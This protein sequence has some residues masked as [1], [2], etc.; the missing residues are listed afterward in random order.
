MT[1]AELS[2]LIQPILAR[3]IEAAKTDAA[4]REQL[5]QLGEALLVLA[6]DSGP[7]AAGSAAPVSVLSVPSGPSRPSGPSEFDLQILEPEPLET[8]TPLNGDDLV[9][10]D[11]TD[12]EEAAE[13]RSLTWDR[14]LVQVADRDLLDIAERCTLKAQAARE[15]ADWSRSSRDETAR[16]RHKRQVEG[17]IAQAR[18]VPDCYLFLN[19]RELTSNDPAAFDTVAGCFDATAAIVALL[20]DIVMDADA[21]N[22][23]QAMALAAE[24]QSAL[25]HAVRATTYLNDKDQLRVFYW[26]RDTGEERRIFVQRYMRKNDVADPQRWP[27]LQRRIEGLADSVRNMQTRKLTKQHMMNKLRYHAKLI[28]SSPEAD[29]AHDWDATLTAVEAMSKAGTPPS[30]VDIRG[31]LLPII[32]S[33]PENVELTPSMALVVREIDHYL[34]TSPAQA[35]ASP[36]NKPEA[37]SDDVKRVATWLKGKSVLM[38]GGDKRP[39]PAR[40]LQ[41]M[42]GLKEL[43]WPETESHQSHYVFE[44]YIARSEVAIVLLAIRWASHGFSEV[45][46]LCDEHAKPLVRLRAGYNPNEVARQIVAQASNRLEGMS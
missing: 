17:L 1:S 2:T 4:L 15:M 40:A 16:A 41:T 33:M 9:E 23:E 30:D 8:L 27:D 6:S 32:E 37:M 18:A 36:N 20:H 24:A 46:A 28:Q 45:K 10:E 39:E 44:P 38:I 26:L 35:D 29:H 12:I 21:P 3:L 42:F 7:A 19:T 22:L 25:L 43:I 31:A 34:S 5:R 14:F 11:T 13:T